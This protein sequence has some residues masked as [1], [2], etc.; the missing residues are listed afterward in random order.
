MM[1]M[2]RI[3]LGLVPLAIMRRMLILS[4]IDHTIMLVIVLL[5]GIKE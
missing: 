5:L 2:M 3:I 4:I 1:M